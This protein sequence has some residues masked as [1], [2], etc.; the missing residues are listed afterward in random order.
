MQLGKYTI[1]ARLIDDAILP[2]YKGSTFRGAFGGCLKK[3]VCAIRKTECTACLLAIKCVYAR[4]F[5]PKIWENATNTRV[6]TPP[7]P[8]II[9]PDDNNRTRFTAGEPFNFNLILF[10]EMNQYLPYFV[11]AFSLM[12]EQGIGKKMGENRARFAL[13]GVS[14]KGKE[15]FCPETNK[16]QPVP[17]PELLSLVPVPPDDKLQSITIT[18]LTPLRFKQENQ[19][20]SRLEFPVLVRSMLR[21]VSSLFNAWGDGEPELDYRGMVARAEQVKVHDGR[22]YWHDWE[23][24]SNRQEKA[25]SFGGLM[26]H[27]TY[28]GPLAEYLPLVELCQ[29]LNLGKQT[30]FGLGQYRV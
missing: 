22:I 9:Q 27:V 10:G 28:H 15:L 8:Y 29:H 7:H 13:Q 14:C 30:T 16:L 11:Y 20:Q 19:L 5:E 1:S 23:R 25:M 6:V 3:A 17:E 24:Y 4:L 18:L 26:G 12:G 21:R 2:A